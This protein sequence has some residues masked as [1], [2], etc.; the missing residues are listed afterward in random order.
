MKKRIVFNAR[1]GKKTPVVP[2]TG[3]P[4]LGASG[5]QDPQNPT[6]GQGAKPKPDRKPNAAGRPIVGVT[7]AAEYAGVSRWTIRAW[8]LSGKIPFIR[9]PGSK[10]DK[11]LRGAKI[12]LKD[13]DA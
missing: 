9:Y 10:D 7:R 11:D 2:K 4:A 1:V 3:S 5:P 6:R 8:M 12:D 13:L